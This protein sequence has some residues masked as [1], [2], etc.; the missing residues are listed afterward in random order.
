VPRT[1][2]LPLQ[3]DQW[4]N[5][6][7][8]DKKMIRQ[9]AFTRRNSIDNAVVQYVTHPKALFGYPGIYLNPHVLRCKLVSDSLQYTSTHVD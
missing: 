3:V 5:K 2:C 4:W 9:D 6:G 7:G 8:L 1:H